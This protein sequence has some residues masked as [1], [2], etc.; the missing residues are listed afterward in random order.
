MHSQSSTLSW[1]EEY[2][3]RIRAT[4]QVSPLADDAFGDRVNLFNGTVSFSATDISLPGNSALPVELVR[5]YDTQDV[6]SGRPLGEW[7]LDLPR[8]SG[9]HPANGGWA[10][11]QR[12]ST[13]APPPDIQAGQYLF[14]ASDY[15]SGNRLQTRNGG[16]DLLAITGD[17]KLVKPTT[18]ASFKWTTRDG[19]FVSCLSSL[20]SGHA[21][22]GFLAVAPD[23]TR[24]YFDWMV[25]RVHPWITKKDPS[26]LETGVLDRRSVRLYATRVEDR[27]GNWVK[28]EWTGDRLNRIHANDGR[29]ITLAYESTSGRLLSAT[30][31]GRTW[32]YESD[33][34]FGLSSV[35][36]PDGSR[37]RYSGAGPGL[38]NRVEYEIDREGPVTGGF[39]RD[40]ENYCWPTNRLLQQTA[41]FTITHPAGASAQFTFSPLR[42]G[43]T[44]VR[45]RCL[46]GTDDDWRTDYN[47]HSL[48]HE[49]MSLMSKRVTGQSLPESLQTYQYSGLE[50]GYAPVNA[51][52]DAV[53]GATPPP[54][55]KYVT[56]HRPDGSAL[57]HRFGKDYALNEGQLLRVDVLDAAGRLLR[58]T[59]NTYI[60]DAEAAASAFPASVGT[61]FVWSGDPLEASLRPL[62]VA[63]IVD[64]GVAEGTSATA[65]CETCEPP[66]PDC[67]P[68]TGVCTEPQGEVETS[69]GTIASTVPPT[70]FTRDI[71]TFDALAR[72]TNVVRSSSLGYTATDSHAYHDDLGRW[73]I[74]QAKRSITNGIETSRTEFD[75]LSRPS[76]TYNF[77]KRQSII[78]YHP[79]GTLAS[80]TDGRNLTTRLSN[81][82]RGLPQLIE[83]PDGTRQSA[84]VDHRGWITSVTDENGY[85]TCYAYDSMGRATTVTHPSETA[86]GV[87]DASAWKPTYQ[88][89]APL[90]APE[91]DVQQGLWKQTIV[92]GDA[93][94]QVYFD[95]LWRPIL[96]REFD[97]TKVTATQR[98]TRR[99]FDE[100]GREAFVSYPGSTHDQT[101]GTWTLYDALGRVTSVSQDSE[102]G[103]LTTRTEYLPG[104]QTRTTNPRGFATTTTT[105]QAYDQPSYD[106]PRGINHPEG[107]FTEIFRDVFGK[108]TQLKRRNADGS[109]VATRQY[110][111]NPRQELCKTIEPET[112][113][114]VFGYDGAGNL[115]WSAAGFDY[116]NPNNC[117]STTPRGTPRAIE[118]TYDA[119][120]RL[121]TMTMSDG[122]GSQEWTYAADGLPT[123]IVTY[124]DGGTTSAVN[125]Y[126]YNRRRLMTADKFE[127]TGWY[128]WSIGSAY[129]A[130]G[131]L[132][133]HTYP[134]G[135][136]V[137]Y[138]PNALG[139]PTQAGT[140]ATGVGY[141]PNGALKQFTYGNGLVHTM[142]QNARQLPHVVTDGGNALAHTYVYDANGNPLQIWDGAQSLGDRLL[143]YDGLDRLTRAQSKMFG[144]D[145]AHHFTY[146]ALDNLKSWKLAGVKDYAKYVYDGSNRLTNI[147]NSNSPA[148]SIVGLGY[149]VQGNLAD[150]SGHGYKFDF[151]N[152]LRTVSRAGTT[153][154]SYRYDGHGRRI[155]NIN[156]STG[157]LIS[158]YSADGKLMYHRDVRSGKNSRTD[159][160]YLA[161]S[162]V[163]SREHDLATGAIKVKYQHTD[164]LGSPVA[165][166]DA[167]G[168]VIERTNYEPYGAAIGKTV[169]GV[170]YTG[171]VMDAATGLTYMQQR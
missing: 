46:S 171:H 96:T 118:R 169:D 113:S 143:V 74:G 156:A 155:Q 120:N 27:F 47:D 40:D 10:P 163:A 133:R 151:G 8:L 37:W 35:V 56:V 145:H 139:Q 4:E 98:F 168:A 147:M 123:K 105:Y 2:A 109:I 150:K 101:A 44:N 23:G 66:P 54:H 38:P 144:G 121:A 95:A 11:A 112:A 76:T 140:Y 45:F 153:V 51:E 33:S 159:Y 70:S 15:W 52:T 3:K 39:I 34:G 5:T 91:W 88:S 141:H 59:V 32:T 94:R 117:E 36:N 49:V 86:L 83:H 90:N 42:H 71:R 161:G 65:S 79:D 164:A 64:R 103:L 124:N 157:T 132:S 30:A 84:V 53:T 61:S 89:F 127:H 166:S 18:G 102:L 69:D 21:G 58:T 68:E 25:L 28:Y 19:W 149:D 165:V 14:L 122:N 167:T 26:R 129:D 104:F 60:T 57:I 62:R 78:G 170:G 100:S 31:A 110:V 138:A 106:F 99:S 126:Q 146:D 6:S 81:W 107:A 111:Y 22:E 1:G 73:V 87:C 75:S 43:R 85:R 12:C 97:G 116:Q 48:T 17:P 142:T 63:S 13:V 130:N 9:V 115:Q 80:V 20:Q 137:D 119:R 135:Q 136:N 67:S 24:Y 158:T 114:T 92:T 131:N 125:T 77:G 134:S 41:A 128:S 7:D 108:P 152:R 148:Q 154:E 16:G 50:A 72:P 162:Q 29:E 82:S 93:Y 160:V 55:Y